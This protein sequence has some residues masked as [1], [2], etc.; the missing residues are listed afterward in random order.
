M[1]SKR[2][3]LTGAGLKFRAVEVGLN[4]LGFEV[5]KNLKIS[6]SPNFRFY[7]FAKKPKNLG[8]KVRILV[9]F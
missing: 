4:N 5:F 8:S 6:K 9:Y 3:V 2:P 7:K 1:C